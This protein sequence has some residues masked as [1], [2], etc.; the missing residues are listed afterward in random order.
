[1]PSLPL[2]IFSGEA[3]RRAAPEVLRDLQVTGERGLSAA[4]VVERQRYGKNIIPEP[5]DRL[6]FLL[7][8]DRFRDPLVIV[9]GLVAAS[10]IVLGEYSDAVIVVIA[11]LLDVLL[12]FTH[13]WRTERALQK[14]KDHVQ[15][16]VTVLREGQLRRIPARELVVGDIIEL[17]AGERVPADARLITAA[18]LSV[19]ESLLT[20]EAND[21]LKQTAR[22]V[23]RT[24]LADRTSM[25]FMG[26]I[27]TAG[28]GQAV[29]TATGT[30]TEY[31]RI[32]QLLK[33]APTPVSPLRRKVQQA[34]IRIG[35]GIG[36]TVLVLAVIQV[37]QKTPLVEAIRTAGTLVVSAIPED[38]T[39]ILTVALTV[40]MVRILRRRGAVRE[41]QSVETLGAVTMI[42]TDKTGTLTQG[43]MTALGFD[44][45]QGTVIDG[46]HPPRDEWHILG[47]TGL[48]IASNARRL[49]S[50]GRVLQYTGSAVERTALAFV[51]R[52]GLSQEQLRRQ[53]RQR[54]AITFS[55]HWKYRASVH[56]H[57]TQASRTLFVTGAPEILLERSSAVLSPRHDVEALSSEH[58]Q[59]LM[60]TIEEHAASGEHMVAVAV[61][62]NYPRRDITHHDIHDLTFIG[63]LTITDPVRPD[64][65]Y[66]LENALAAGIEVKLVTGDHAAT[67][68]AVAHAVG[69]P[70]RS[71]AVCSGQELAY[72]SDEELKA[73]VAKTVIFSR[74]TPLDKQRIIRA[75]QASG[76]HIV[77]MTGDGINDSVALKTAD[78]GVAMGSGSDIAKDAADL[79]LLD[80]SFSTIVAAIREGRVV[81]DNMRKVLGFLL[82]TNVAEVA[83]FFGS[84]LLGLPIPLLPAQILWINLVTD[85][86]SDVA[87]SLEPAERSVMR[88]R[89]E[90]VQSPL[91][92]RSVLWGISISGIVMTGIAMGLYW[93]LY[94]YVGVDVVYART[95]TFTFVAVSSLLSTWSWRSLHE[96]IH[97]RGLWQNRW[98]V[99]CTAASLLLQLAALYLPG[100]QRFF[101]TVALG[102]RDW[103]L[104][105][106]LSLVAVV[107]IDM[108]KVFLKKSV[109]TTH[110]VLKTRYRYAR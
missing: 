12:S 26:T 70:V 42:C 103:F 43:N 47:L 15:Q 19:Q 9:L 48:V 61:R 107:I 100:F 17:M 14:L 51:E 35:M 58:R 94:Q 84:I 37:W 65:K 92:P 28:S 91:L 25:V 79:V 30:R 66:A 105:G 54:D 90:K 38:L 4:A 68:R 99:V 41:L 16:I 71:G 3:Y 6:P 98:V 27:I 97:Q 96:P 108:R 77:A 81:R 34:S 87:L 5:R 78:V 7:F 23:S 57:P 86:T 20:G 62:K 69:L 110:A 33:T 52:V 60:H 82:A 109:K 80:D 21:V 31:G 76:T 11:L 53:W 46:E 55:P 104:L 8:I 32:A 63:V 22:L 39:M 64:V 73:T 45:L 67:A 29:V 59:Q 95:M 44:C 74:V 88:R 36:I 89:P 49:A 85:G 72:L 24:P 102:P 101:G 83:I 2:P 13:V 10:F 93:Y 1:M 75:L 56:D 40:G 106:A 18:G 50:E